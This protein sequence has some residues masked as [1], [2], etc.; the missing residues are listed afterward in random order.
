MGGDILSG[1]EGNAGST[2]STIDAALE[3]QTKKGHA[4]MPTAH[5]PHK[6]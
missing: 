6:N 5:M 1:V 4:E 2:K 3:L